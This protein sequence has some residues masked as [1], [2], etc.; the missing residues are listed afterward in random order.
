MGLRACEA[1]RP[2]RVPSYHIFDPSVVVAHQPEPRRAAREHDGEPLHFGVRRA[3]RRERRFLAF[4]V[5]LASA[6]RRCR[7][8]LTGGA[9]AGE[10]EQR[11]RRET[12]LGRRAVGSKPTLQHE[13]VLGARGLRRG[14]AARGERRGCA[15][16]REAP[17]SETR[18]SVTMVS[19]SS[20]SPRA[21]PSTARTRS[22]IRTS[23][24]AEHGVPGSSCRGDGAGLTE[25][26]R[27]APNCARI[28]RLRTVR[29]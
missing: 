5:P 1:P 19:F 20:F 25:L 4:P 16:V 17:Q 23:G 6:R 12:P 28:A 14:G 2:R 15:R 7:G 22:W 8:Q 18:P 13:S 21:I 3:A 27:I 24:W 29:I 9:L 10:A 26:R 11:A